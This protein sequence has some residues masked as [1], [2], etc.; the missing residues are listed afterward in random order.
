[1]GY[2]LVDPA[3]MLQIFIKHMIYSHC[4]MIWSCKDMPF[5]K[6]LSTEERYREI[7]NDYTVINVV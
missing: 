1:M 7:V 2:Y 5:L 6:K 3:I 4:P